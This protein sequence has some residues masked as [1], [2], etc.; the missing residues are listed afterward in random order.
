MKTMIAG[1]Q[2]EVWLKEQEASFKANGNTFSELA[3]VLKE[4]EDVLRV[5]SLLVNPTKRPKLAARIAA[6]ASRIRHS[7]G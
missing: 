5:V 6:L 7:G 2:L 4:T 3:A 1:G